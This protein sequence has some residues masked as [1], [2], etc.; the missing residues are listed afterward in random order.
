MIDTDEESLHP[1]PSPNMMACL[2][3]GKDC[4][5]RQ[6]RIVHLDRNGHDHTDLRRRIAPSAPFCLG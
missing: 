4:R 3:W 2:R 6:P 1:S 5:C